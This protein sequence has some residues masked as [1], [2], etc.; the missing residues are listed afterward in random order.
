MFPDE[1]IGSEWLS[2]CLGSHSNLRS[3]LSVEELGLLTFSSGFVP[4]GHLSLP[5]G[6]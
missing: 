1:E 6:L 5:I 2:D 4:L 3:E